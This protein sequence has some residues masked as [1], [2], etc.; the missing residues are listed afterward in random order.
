MIDQNKQ[1]GQGDE[2]TEDLFTT[3]LDVWRFL[4]EDGWKIGR[5]AFYNHCNDGLLRPDKKT[6]K[7]ALKKVEKYAKLHV[8]R[9]DTD[10]KIN[11]KYDKMQEEKLVTEL[12]RE[13]IRL[14][15]EIHDLGIKQKKFIPR[16][17]F[18]LAVVGRAVAMLAHLKHMVQMKAPDWVDTVGGD[19]E[20]VPELVYEITGNI[21]THLSVFAKDVEFDVILEAD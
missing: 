4:K 19:Q 21:E 13:K 12:E 9:A 20:H 2:E 15:K 1:A 16:E 7:Y 18:E 8:K 6:G 5:A 10:Q 3:K 17:D 11:D 14:Q